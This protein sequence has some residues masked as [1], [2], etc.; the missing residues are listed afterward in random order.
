MMLF[1]GFDV[2]QLNLAG[3][4]DKDL[5]SV[6]GFLGVLSHMAVVWTEITC[7]TTACCGL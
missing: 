2:S 3:M 5:G 4:E 6:W 7:V 1:Q